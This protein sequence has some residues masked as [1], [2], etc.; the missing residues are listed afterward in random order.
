MIRK[1]WPIFEGYPFPERFVQLDGLSI[2]YVD[3]GYGGRPI[4]MVHGNPTWSYIWRRLIPPV[5]ME[6]RAIA[7]DLMGFGKS[8][9]P[10]PILHDFPHHARIVSSF[11]QSLGLRN[12]VLMVHDWGGPFAMHYAARHP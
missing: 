5:S 1:G 6:H 4:L 8:D 2:H 9:K 10:N 7:L 11:V 12:I 3:A